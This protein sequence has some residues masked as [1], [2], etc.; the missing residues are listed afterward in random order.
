MPAVALM[1]RCAHPNPPF[2]LF[3]SLSRTVCS[4]VWADFRKK[5][6]NN[7]TKSIHVFFP[8]SCG[9]PSELN[10]ACHELLIFWRLHILCLHTHTPDSNRWALL[11]LSLC[12]SLFPSVTNHPNPGLDCLLTL[13]SFGN[14][15]PGHNRLRPPSPPPPLLRLPKP[16]DPSHSDHSYSLYGLTGV[17]WHSDG[18]IR[19]VCVYVCIQA[20]VRH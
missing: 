1:L 16:R 6:N 13:G 9:G 4:S 7:K 17:Y 8:S 12:F 18:H 11:L 10:H 2:S 5:N 3:L 20:A 15:L 14:N 19:A